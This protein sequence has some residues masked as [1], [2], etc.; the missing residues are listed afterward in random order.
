MGTLAV[1]A[2]MVTLL[3]DSPTDHDLVIGSV[4]VLGGVLLR[5]EA[6]LRLRGRQS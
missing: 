4:L 3:W 2:G 6:A 1:I 5:I